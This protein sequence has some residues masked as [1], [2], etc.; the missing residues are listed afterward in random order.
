M[1]DYYKNAPRLRDRNVMPG[2]Y[3]VKFAKFDYA[4]YEAC[5]KI[6]RQGP[7]VP[8]FTPDKLIEEDRLLS[9][10]EVRRWCE[11]VLHRHNV[12]AAE[13]VDDQEC[14]GR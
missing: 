8:L 13:W 12:P 9:L 2:H 10:C 4:F 11:G 1:V 6:E 5:L 14:Q 7:R 3:A